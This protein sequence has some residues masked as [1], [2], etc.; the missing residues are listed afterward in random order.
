MELIKLKDNQNLLLQERLKLASN[1]WI[2]LHKPNQPEKDKLVKKKKKS[3]IKWIALI[4][5]PLLG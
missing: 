2:W 5:I 4:N 3:S 1:S